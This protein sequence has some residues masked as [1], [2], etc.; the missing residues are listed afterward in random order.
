MYPHIGGGYAP[1][2]AVS[3]FPASLKR[4]EASKFYYSQ[5]NFKE[6]TRSFEPMRYKTG[7][8]SSFALSFFILS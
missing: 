2:F 4:A 8:V 6:R 7:N 1:D 3:M 5:K